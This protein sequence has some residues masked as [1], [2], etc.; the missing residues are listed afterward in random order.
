MRSAAWM[1]FDK[2][3]RQGGKCLVAAIPISYHPNP[4]TAPPQSKRHP[5]EM[6]CRL[7]HNEAVVTS[8]SSMG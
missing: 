5:S 6:T 3:A 2:A 1:N 4:N 7:N 8:T